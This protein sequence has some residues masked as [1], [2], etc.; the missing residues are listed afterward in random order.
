MA[1]VEAAVDYPVAVA[2][3]L[4]SDGVATLRDRDDPVARPMRE[5]HA[6]SPDAA[7]RQRASR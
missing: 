6:R 2:S 4:S 3:Q 7:A 5:E 1:A